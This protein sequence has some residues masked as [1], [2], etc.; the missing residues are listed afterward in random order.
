[1]LS[2][3]AEIDIVTYFDVTART[4]SEVDEASVRAM[5]AGTKARDPVFLSTL[6][7]PGEAFARRHPQITVDSDR[8][9]VLRSVLLKP[10]HEQHTAWLV[11]RLEDFMTS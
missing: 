10:E 7:V 2:Q 6:S 9:R 3:P 5:E 11:D 1:M 4:T 8:V